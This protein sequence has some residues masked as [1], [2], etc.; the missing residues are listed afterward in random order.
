[1]L[2]PSGSGKS[3]WVAVLS[4][5]GQPHSWVDGDTLI[6]W[7]SDWSATPES[8]HSQSQTHAA[9]VEVAA[10]RGASVIVNHGDA[11]TLD[12]WQ[13]AGLLAGAWV[14]GPAEEFVASRLAAG[15]L[16]DSQRELLSNCYERQVADYEARG[17]KIWRGVDCPLPVEGVSTERR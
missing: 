8:R 6:S 4:S 13:A 14:P 17:L 3:T 10:S 5:S 16:R 2:A 12:R 11:A 9:A 7:P 1:M 15:K